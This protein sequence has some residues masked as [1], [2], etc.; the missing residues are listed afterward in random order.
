VL[1]FDFQSLYPSVM[2]AYN[3]CYS[4]CLGSIK[5]LFKDGKRKK[6]GVNE[7]MTIHLDTLA[8]LL[9]TNKSDEELIEHLSSTVLVTPNRVAFVRK[10]LKEGFIPKI[11]LEF[12]LTRIMIKNSSKLYRK[13]SI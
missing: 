13:E 4:T 5:E 11:L 7:D 2:I 6:L 10:N 1:L 8:Q 12:L 9:E 3:L